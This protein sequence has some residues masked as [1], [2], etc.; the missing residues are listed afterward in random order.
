VKD[1]L[2]VVTV[3][4]NQCASLTEVYTNERKANTRA[5]FLRN[6]WQGSEK[7]I[8]VAECGKFAPGSYGD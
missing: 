3:V 4:R 5:A 1:T 8:H 6:L 7:V 2:F